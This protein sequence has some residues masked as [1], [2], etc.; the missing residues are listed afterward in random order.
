M[1]QEKELQPYQKSLLPFDPIVLLRDALKK[2]ALIL[3]VAVICGMGAYIY[4]FFMKYFI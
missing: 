2:W 3:V 1:E 4:T